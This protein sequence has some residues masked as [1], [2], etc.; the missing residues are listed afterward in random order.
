MSS[1]SRLH[2]AI[3][4]WY[5]RSQAGRTGFST[6]DILIPLEQLLVAAGCS[7]GHERAWAE[8]QL[9]RLQ[10]NG[11]ILL[12]PVHRRDRS[13]IGQVRISP[14]READ[15][16]RALGKTAPTEMRRALAAQFEDAALFNVPESW[17]SPWSKW[18]EGMANAALEGR[19]VKPFDHS[20]TE[21]NFRLLSLLPKLL[22]W[23]GESLV[24]F[25][26]CVLCE[27]SKTLERLSAIERQG[28]F[29]GKL[30]GKLGALLSDITGGVVQTLDDLGILPN[31]RF[32]LAHGPL[33]LRFD[34]G[35]LNLGLLQGPFC[36]S[37]KDID[38]ASEVMTSSP[39]CL[40]V[41]NETSFHEL[42][43]LNSGELLIQTS[44]PGS[45][46]LALLRRLPSSLE[47]WHFGDSD[48]PGFEI[49][50]VLREKSGRNFQPLHMQ[51]GRIPAEQESLGRPTQQN[52]PF[53][54]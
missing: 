48:D 30:R 11:V 35:G 52:W 16:Y 46:T 43:K 42:A 51:Q 21:A 18:C 41:E 28:E 14:T 17:R 22:G 12:D 2:D 33:Q 6:R 36:L 19:S 47:F 45:G 15:L 1:S 13:R 5:E 24:R 32:A 10:S 34:H 23:Q 27:D 37:Q 26:S 20:S 49:L 40:T 53:Y 3:A 39:R 44:Y 54:G 38:Q 9:M 7:E 8:E 4:Q 29:S 25:A 50:R 31:P